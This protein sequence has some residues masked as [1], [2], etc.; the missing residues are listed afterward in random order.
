MS[1][2]CSRYGSGSFWLGEEGELAEQRVSGG[3]QTFCNLD[4]LLGFVRGGCVCR[5]ARIF[6]L[7]PPTPQVREWLES[8]TKLCSHR[9][10][11]RVVTPSVVARMPCC[12][13]RE[14][15]ANRAAS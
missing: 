5:Q 3:D 6:Q 15:Q 12:A 9:A 4:S 14:M 13:S 10:F 2:W 1:L 8:L 7:I 11:H